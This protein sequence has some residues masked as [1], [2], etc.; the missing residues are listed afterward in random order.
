MEAK[1]T[2]QK[3]LSFTGTAESGFELPLGTRASAGGDEDGFRPMEL[4]AIGLA[5]CTAMDVI[6]ILRKK[7]QDV[8]HFVVQAH[9]D[10]EIE[11]PKVFTQG[12][13]EYLLTGHNLDEVAVIRSIELSITRY[14][15]GYA[16]MSKVIPI[17]L[18][19]QIFEG[20]GVENRMPVRSG[21][22]LP[23]VNSEGQEV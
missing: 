10:R 16:M 15:P 22:Y 23:P 11:H 6:S 12:V 3:N 17:R 5:G 14:C 13:I 20:D 4:F 9:L 2:W 21:E 18:R 1:V 19:Y 8:T 7:R